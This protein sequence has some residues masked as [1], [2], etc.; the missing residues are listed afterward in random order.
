MDEKRRSDEVDGSD[1]A[2]FRAICTDGDVKGICGAVNA[3]EWP[4]NT[5]TGQSRA[6]IMEA[7]SGVTNNMVAKGKAMSDTK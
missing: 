6:V 1:N 7:A 3:N 5:M 4:A 2:I